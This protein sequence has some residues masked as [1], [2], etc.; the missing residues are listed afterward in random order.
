MDIQRFITGWLSNE[1]KELKNK[2]VYN[3]VKKPAVQQNPP[4]FDPDEFWKSAITRS[5]EIMAELDRENQ[6]RNQWK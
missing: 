6:A 2:P 3:A 5:Q 4:G 1:L